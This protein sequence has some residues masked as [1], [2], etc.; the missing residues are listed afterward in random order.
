LKGVKGARKGKG[1]GKR[2][3]GIP[4]TGKGGKHKGGIDKPNDV[5]SFPNC[6]N[7]VILNSANTKAPFWNRVK[8]AFKKVGRAVGEFFHKVGEFINDAVNND[9]N[10]APE[11]E[12]TSN[13]STSGVS[14]GVGPVSAGVGWE[15]LKIYVSKGFWEAGR[16]IISHDFGP[17]WSLGSGEIPTNLKEG[18]DAELLSI[19]GG[20]LTINNNY[21]RNHPTR[22]LTQLLSG[23]TYQTFQ[24]SAG[25]K[26]THIDVL[27]KDK[28]L[29]ATF[30]LHSFSLS[31]P[32]FSISEVSEKY[33]KLSFPMNH[34]DSVKTAEKG[35]TPS[36]DNYYEKNK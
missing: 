35:N 32:S 23:K 36:F 8:N 24:F 22:S 27:T 7:C 26:Y 31:L 18:V 5:I 10:Y 12:M 14:I 11:L 25:Y 15:Y 33:F 28:V 17:G 1:R 34:G 30:N 21:W 29:V 19:G 9:R 4:R 16:S 13:T 3:K 20:T 6:P 2:S